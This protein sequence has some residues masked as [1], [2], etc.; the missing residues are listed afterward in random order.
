METLRWKAPDRDQRPPDLRPD[1]KHSFGE[2]ELRT[3]NHIKEVYICDENL[4]QF[5]GDGQFIYC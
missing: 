1:R 4:I 5:Q 2:K 3:V